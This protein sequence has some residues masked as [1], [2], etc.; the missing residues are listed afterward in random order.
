MA[1][2]GLAQ[3]LRGACSELCRRAQ[4][5]QV[6]GRAFAKPVLSPEPVEGSRS[7]AHEISH[8]AF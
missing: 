4:D 6:R 3:I 8:G 1:W 5:D 7:S 2:L